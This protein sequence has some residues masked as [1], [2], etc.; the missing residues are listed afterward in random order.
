MEA[1]LDTQAN[2][3]TD[4]EEVMDQIDA[5]EWELT[6]AMIRG[7]RNEVKAIRKQIAALKEAK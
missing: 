1:T 6:R 3:R 2:P 5:L 4:L 7:H